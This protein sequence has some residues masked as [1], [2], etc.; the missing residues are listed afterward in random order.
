MASGSRATL[1]APQLKPVLVFAV[2]FL[3]VLVLH[4]PLLRLPY[5]WDEAG[6]YVPAAHDLLLT[7]IL[8]PHSTPSN[9]HP[10]LVMAYLA[11]WWKIAAYS[12][13]VT[14]TAMLLLAAFSLLG[15]FRLAQRVANIEVAL[16]ATVCTALYPVF[17]AQSSLAHLDL[18]A[19]G[20]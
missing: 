16:A 12:P 19:A 4:L 9:A 3:A 8:V 2:F 14:R 13:A 7:G 18:A 20:L 17:F 5:F 1:S 6:Y 10:P 11:A 15:V